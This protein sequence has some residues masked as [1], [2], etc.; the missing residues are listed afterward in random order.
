MLIMLDKY[1]KKNNDQTL[2]FETKWVDFN[3]S[4]KKIPFELGNHL[5]MGG[6]F[7]VRGDNAIKTIYRYIIKF[8][9]IYR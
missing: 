6:V 9:I 8:L 1:F 7:G 3:R 5:Y 2:C 4:L